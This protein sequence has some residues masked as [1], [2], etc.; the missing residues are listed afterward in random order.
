MNL[1][2][3]AKPVPNVAFVSLQAAKYFL[4]VTGWRHAWYHGWSVWYHEGGRPGAVRF[5]RY[6]KH[7]R[8]LVYEVL[9]SSPPEPEVTYYFRS[10]PTPHLSS[11]MR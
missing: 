1:N 3:V 11:H 9:P 7:R 2:T 4:E 5:I 10:F 8:F 6:E